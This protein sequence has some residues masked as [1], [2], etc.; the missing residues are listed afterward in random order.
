MNKYRLE[1]LSDGVFS[2]LMTLL[3]IELRVPEITSKLNGSDLFNALIGLN[4][5]FLAFFLSFIVITM[6]W[7]SHHTFMAKFTKH[8]NRTVVILNAFLLATVS[9]VPF[10]ANLIGAYTYNQTAIIWYGMNIIL[11]GLMSN[12]LWY[13]ITTSDSLRNNDHDSKELLQ[14]RIR[15]SL[16]PF[17]AILGII[18]SFVLPSFSYVLYAFPVIFNL[19]PRSLDVVEKAFGI[20]LEKIAEKVAK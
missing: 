19:I 5:K 10:S 2:I 7:V 20:D 12:I 15:T 9:L 6:M 13:Y 3:I 8:I 16:N 11:V 14:A 18:M 17:F 1:A 4:S